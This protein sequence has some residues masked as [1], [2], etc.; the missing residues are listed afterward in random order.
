[1]SSVRGGGESKNSGEDMK[2][3][4]DMKKKANKKF[5]KQCAEAGRRLRYM[6]SYSGGGG[7]RSNRFYSDIR[8]SKVIEQRRG[9]EALRIENEKLKYMIE[10][11]KS[12]LKK[13]GI[14]SLLNG[15]RLSDEARGWVKCLSFEDK[16]KIGNKRKGGPQRRKISDQRTGTDGTG[17]HFC[18]LTHR[19][20]Y[21]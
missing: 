15:D 3:R 16:K 2:R 8:N 21:E 18:Y 4:E 20:I 11:Y 5:K 10:S 14:E 19:M 12:F 9:E 6:R 7:V 17:K 13:Y 1:M